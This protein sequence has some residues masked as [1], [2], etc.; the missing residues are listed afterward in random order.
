[1]EKIFFHLTVMDGYPPVSTE[2]LWAQKTQEGYFKIDNIPFYS[3]EVSLG[4]IVSAQKKNGDGLRYEK[5]IRHSRNS[6][7]RIL[8]FNESETFQAGVLNSLIERGCEWEAFNKNF[9][10][11]NIPI[12]INI[13]D[14]YELLDKLLI[15]H[16]LEYE[17]GYL[18][19]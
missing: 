2:S 3:K 13:E 12:Q 19:Q 8:F 4:D 18:A 6:T 11:V 5:T 10:A 16:D 14:I 7:L 9:Y 1:M 15:S 17:T